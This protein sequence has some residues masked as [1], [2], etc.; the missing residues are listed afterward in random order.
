[1]TSPRTN[2]KLPLYCKTSPSH[3]SSAF[4]AIYLIRR[5]RTTINEDKDPVALLSIKA[6]KGHLVN[7]SLR[8]LL[9][10]CHS[11]LVKKMLFLYYL[12]SLEYVSF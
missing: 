9:A 4:S 10:F 6:C 5:G 11:R 8:L 7:I 3:N 12:I 2:S 1:M